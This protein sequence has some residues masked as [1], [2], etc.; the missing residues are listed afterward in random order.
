MRDLGRKVGAYTVPREPCGQRPTP[1][2]SAPFRLGHPSG[3]QR[4]VGRS[5]GHVTRAYDLLAGGDCPAEGLWLD[6][7]N[8]PG[9]LGLSKPD[10][11]ELPKAALNFHGPI[12]PTVLWN[13]SFFFLLLA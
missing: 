6:T 8:T 4:L 10:T 11:A 2:L 12:L 3:Q 7:K 13:S 1:P 5:Q 9:K